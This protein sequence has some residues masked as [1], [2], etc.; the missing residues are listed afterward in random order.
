MKLTRNLYILVSTK[1]MFMKVSDIRLHQE[2]YKSFIVHHEKQP[3]TPWHHHPEY[4]LV[5]I[6]KGKGK[7][8]V[9]DNVSPFEKNDLI[10]L[11]P[12]LP[13]QWVCDVDTNNKSDGPE[14]EAFVIQ[15]SYDFLGTKFFEI[16]EN[17]LLK[18]FLLESSRGYEFYGKTK[19]H[20]ITFLH[21]MFIMNDVDRLYALLNIFKV[22]MFS[23]EYSTLASPNANDKFSKSAN[24]PMRVAMQYTLQNFQKRIQIKDLLELTNMSYASFYLSFRK[25]HLVPFKDYL[26]NVRV[27]FACKL[28][29]EGLMNISEIAYK[30]GFENLSNFNRQ[31][32]RIKHVT[33]TQFQKQCQLKKTT[34]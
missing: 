26:L 7:R 10:F 20:I 18:R 32:K 21:K 13:H 3:F 16:P 30:S 11:G 4:E 19:E 34:N 25:A 22:M 12:Y 27:G 2:P 15:F 23:N 5:L 31:F 6:L 28:L 8:M 24:E 9:G 29:A 33:P 14:D 1:S 17:S